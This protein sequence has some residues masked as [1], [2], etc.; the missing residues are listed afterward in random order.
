[1]RNFPGNALLALGLLLM[2]AALLLEDFGLPHGLKLLMLLAAIA[3]ELAG[4]ARQC[5]E[6]K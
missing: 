6:K 3:L 2:S 5:R 4:T 1:M